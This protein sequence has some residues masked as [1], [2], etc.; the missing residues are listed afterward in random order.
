M[1]VDSRVFNR[2][3]KK[4]AQ[5]PD[6]LLDEA[7]ELTREN[8]PSNSGYARR[9]TIKK[10]NSIVSDYPYAGRLDEGYSRQAPNGF[11]EPTIKQL[12]KEAKN[13]ARKI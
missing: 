1:K 11:T 3:I 4:L 6:V 5:L 13:I 12:S 9:N 7:L 10:G 2:R 8:T